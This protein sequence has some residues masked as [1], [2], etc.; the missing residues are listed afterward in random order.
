ML[1]SENVRSLI[2]TPQAQQVNCF[3]GFHQ[4]IFLTHN[5]WTNFKKLFFYYGIRH[6][7]NHQ[8][9]AIVRPTSQAL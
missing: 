7:K 1:T 3:Q 8:E 4:I 6:E 5:I 2:H 9:E